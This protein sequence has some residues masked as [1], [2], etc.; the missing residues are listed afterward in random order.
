MWNQRGKRKRRQDT[1]SRN[2]ASQFSFADWL[3]VAEQLDLHARHFTRTAKELRNLAAGKPPTRL[4][5]TGRRRISEAAK[6][7]WEDYRGSRN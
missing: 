5:E 4:S 3:N 1:D 2:V 7:K 6:K